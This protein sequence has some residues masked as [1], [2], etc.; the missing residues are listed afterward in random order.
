VWRFGTL[1]RT[2]RILGFDEVLKAICSLILI[3]SN[4]G[5]KGTPK[6]EIIIYKYT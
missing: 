3:K 1:Y 4:E 2:G 6:I 5:F